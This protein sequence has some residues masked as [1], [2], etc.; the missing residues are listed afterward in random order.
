MCNKSFIWVPLILYVVINFIMCNVC[1][2]TAV[3]CSALYI[4][5]LPFI[6][7][8]IEYVRV[9]RFWTWKSQDKRF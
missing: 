6:L 9:D 8:K 7:F 3:N 1:G 4:L 2:F 5:H